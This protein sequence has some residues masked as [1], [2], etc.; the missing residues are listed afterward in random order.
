MTV[1][2]IE[3]YLRA[4]R[5]E[6][7]AP[8]SLHRH[9]ATLSLILRAA[10]RR[11][12]VRENPVAMVERP[13]AT[14]RR[15]RILSPA[16]F[17]VVGQAWDE[18]EEE[19]GRDQDRDD[20]RVSKMMFQTMMRTGIRRGEALGLRW[21]H[22]LLADPDGPVLRVEETYVR[23]AIDT[24]K[25]EAGQRT[26]SLGPMLSG[27]LFDFRAA[28]NYGDDDERVFANPRTGNPFNATVYGDLLREALKRAGVEGYVRPCHDLRHSSITN[29]AAAGH[30]PEA[31]MSRAGHSDY[32][33]TRRYVDLAG[34]R[35]REEGDKLEER[36]AGGTGTKNRYKVAPSSQGQETL[37]SATPV[38]V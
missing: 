17:I 38:V 32:A 7:L 37:E 20:V 5:A 35:F 27:E 19:A 15:W 33:T 9:L 31:L 8:A 10:L 18:M 6:G 11:R 13:K 2:L 36:L 12:L 30:S 14:R 26:I 16:E 34:E 1:E 25:S 23:N 4:K 21:R 22:V 3:S 24:P 28:S 29:A